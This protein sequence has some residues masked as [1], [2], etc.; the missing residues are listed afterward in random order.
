MNSRAWVYFLSVYIWLVG[1]GS[2]QAANFEDFSF[3]ETVEVHTDAGGLNTCQDI[4]KYSPET[5]RQ[6]IDLVK[7]ANQ[8]GKK[9]ILTGSSHS[10]A[11]QVACHRDA[12]PGEYVLVTLNSMPIKHELDGR[13]ITISAQATWKD[14][15]EV[16]KTNDSI[17]P[18]LAPSI[19]QDFNVFTIAGTLSANAM[20][21]DPNFG[22]VIESVQ[23][24]TLLKADGEVIECSRQRNKNCFE[25]VIGGYGAFGVILDAK[26][27]LVPDVAI[28]SVRLRLSN[29]D[30]AEHL[31]S[32][33]V[34]VEELDKHYG[35]I[36]IEYGR[37][38]VTVQEYYKVSEQGLPFWAEDLKQSGR[39][40]LSANQTTRR[41]Y[42][43]N[44][45]FSYKWGGLN[46]SS[47]LLSVAIP[48]QRYETFSNSIPQLVTSFPSL[49]FH[50]IT[51]RFI[52][53]QIS[54]NMLQLITQDSIVF[55]FM[56][57]NRRVDQPSL[58]LFKKRLYKLARGTGG[59]PDL[60][61]DLPRDAGWV[62]DSYPRVGEWLA[63][64]REFDPSHTFYSKFFHNFQLRMTGAPRK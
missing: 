37:V 29:D 53:E 36:E 34:G 58:E 62:M 21:R 41:E 14:L 12:T 49:K 45:R 9:L 42:L 64:K 39:L 11:G 56:I 44:H 26:V 54:P 6:L 1:Y 24:F 10:M 5:R 40:P 27:M 48:L 63:L 33:V 3:Y 50:E 20:G 52:P 17:G 2:A 30:Y 47:Q 51:T 38:F 13:Y 25:A 22:P 28:Q 15:I 31:M 18:G 8:S 57:E 23:S 59:K 32:N 61:F 46:Q 7:S 60:A 16:L 35:T 4:R 19:M 55:V 43:D